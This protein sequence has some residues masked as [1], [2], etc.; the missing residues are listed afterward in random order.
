MVTFEFIDESGRPLPNAKFYLYQMQGDTFVKAIH[1]HSR[2]DGTARIT[3]RDVPADFIL[4][5]QTQ[6]EFYEKWWTPS[7]LS[8]SNGTV[9]L[10]VQKTGVI[11]LR[12]GSFP[13][14]YSDPLVVSC[15]KV[16]TNGQYKEVS[17]IGMFFSSEE[18][19]VGGLEE[20]LYRLQL[21]HNYEDDHAIWEEFNIM[22]R[23]GQRT[24][25]SN[26]VVTAEDL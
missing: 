21:K 3:V 12:F 16:Q 9:R 7:D 6:N 4:G 17:G 24:T 14:A 5:V 11:A 8:L 15:S 1:R 13:P 19:P 2:L 25:I 23:A 26:I 22:V 18:T 10:Q 20:G